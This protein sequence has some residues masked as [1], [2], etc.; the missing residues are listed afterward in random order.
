MR[1]REEL[2]RFGH[3][4]AEKRLVWGRSGNISLKLSDDTF[5]ITATGSNLG[6]L[7]DDELTTCQI[8]DDKWE[9]AKPPS[10]EKDLHRFIYQRQEKAKAII[11]AHPFHATLVACTRMPLSTDIFPEAMAYLGSIMRVPYFH[12]GSLELAQAVAETAV[13]SQVL[14]LENHGTIISA[15]S[16]DDA[17]LK[18]ETLELLCRLVITARSAGIEL[19]Y[20]GKAAKEDFRE[21][22]KRISGSFEA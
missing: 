10:M 6:A 16:L 15:S 9:G 13:S 19:K 3:Q 20:L 8:K 12:P 17:M 5:L 4:L 11:H 14:L 22:L 7:A 2:K 21:H 1:M 18:T